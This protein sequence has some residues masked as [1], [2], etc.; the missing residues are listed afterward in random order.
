MPVLR[1]D[2]GFADLEHTNMCYR[3]DWCDQGYNRIIWLTQ[4]AIE[5]FMCDNC[6]ERYDVTY[7]Q[8]RRLR[9]IESRREWTSIVG[10]WVPWPWHWD[11]GEE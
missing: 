9:Y 8:C 10:L 4:L 5:Y 3:C 7:E 6:R 1:Y 2:N 11:K